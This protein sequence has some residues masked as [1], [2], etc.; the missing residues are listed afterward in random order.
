[1]TFT[2]NQHTDL[3]GKHAYLSASHHVWLNYD[4]E[5]FKDIFYSNL[6]KERGTQLHAFAEFANR[7]GRKMPR[8]HETINEFIN[9]GLGYNMS[10]EVVLYYSEYCFG[11]ADLIGFDPKKKLLRVFD[12]KTGQKDVLEFGQL[13]VYCA[14]FCLEYNIKPDDIKFECRLYQNDEVRIEEFTDPETIK[15]VMNLIVHDDKMIRELRAEAKANKL[16]F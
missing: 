2:F 13:H 3:Q 9:D 10:P 16:I 11:T 8:N 5:H 12:L 6:M 14:L 4:D 15:D 1:M 7:M